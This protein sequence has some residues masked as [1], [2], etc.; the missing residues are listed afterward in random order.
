MKKADLKSGMI[1]ELRNGN[2]YTVMKNTS[3]G[4]VLWGKGIKVFSE[5]TPELRHKKCENYDIIRIFD[6]ESNSA[7][8][9]KANYMLIWDREIKIAF[10]SFPNH[11]KEYAYTVAGDIVNAGDKV[12]VPTKQ[13]GK[14]LAYVKTVYENIQE[15]Q[16]AG[17]KFGLDELKGIIGAA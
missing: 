11:E 10:V 6:L 9:K 4:N 8:V 14:A 13:Q 15:A 2:R 12:Y 3:C 17:L 5:F 16:K 7:L 1:V